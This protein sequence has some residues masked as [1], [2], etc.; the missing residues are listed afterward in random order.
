MV[1]RDK[2]RAFVF[3]QRRGMEAPVLGGLSL[4]VV[5]DKKDGAA[6]ALG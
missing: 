4:C 2:A 3:A 5:E 1:W 6:D